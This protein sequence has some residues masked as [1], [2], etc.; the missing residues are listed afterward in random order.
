M[1]VHILVWTCQMLWKVLVCIML[2]DFILY[3]GYPPPTTRWSARLWRPSLEINRLVFWLLVGL[4]YTHTHQINI[5]CIYIH[6][7]IIY[8]SIYPNIRLL[9]IRLPKYIPNYKKTYPIIWW[10]WNHH[11]PNS[12]KRLQKNA[13]TKTVSQTNVTLSN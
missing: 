9:D 2:I 3:V 12:K 11:K 4:G 7:Y 1:H 13:Q 5:L 10:D 8:E 6:T